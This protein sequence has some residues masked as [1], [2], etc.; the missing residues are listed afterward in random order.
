MDAQTDNS[1]DRIA[2]N[3]EAATFGLPNQQFVADAQTP[4]GGQDD[5]D[6]RSAAREV[7]T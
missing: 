6:R 4:L 7:S 2:N 1:I 5:D 3:T